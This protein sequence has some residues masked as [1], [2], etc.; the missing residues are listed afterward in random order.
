[1]EVLHGP[2]V[3]SRASFMSLHFLW[4]SLICMM[5]AFFEAIAAV[6]SDKKAIALFVWAGLAYKPW[7]K[8]LLAGLV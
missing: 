5:L 6:T 2:I 8:V 7:L 4:L 1:M 3:L